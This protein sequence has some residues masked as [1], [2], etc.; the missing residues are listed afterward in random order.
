MTRLIAGSN[1]FRTAIEL[2]RDDFESAE[3]V[4]IA[5]GLFEVVSLLTGPLAVQLDAPILLV[6]KGLTNELTAELRRLGAENVYIVGG[7][8]VV[9]ATIAD[10]IAALGLDV[11]RYGGSNRYGTALMVDAKVRELSGVTDLAVIVNGSSMV[12]A[13]AMGAPAGK[14]GVGFLLNDGKSLARI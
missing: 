8:A 12:D 2:S 3:H 10:D 6:N 11:T 4:I 9:N 7:E 5:S 13:L 14:M 1:R